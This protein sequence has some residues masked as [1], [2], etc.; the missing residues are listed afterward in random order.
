MSNRLRSIINMCAM[1]G[2]F[3][4]LMEHYINLVETDYSSRNEIKRINYTKTKVKYQDVNPD[5]Y[6]NWRFQNKGNINRCSKICQKGLEVRIHNQEI[7]QLEEKRKIK[8]GNFKIKKVKIPKWKYLNPKF[9][10][11][12]HL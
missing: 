7:K 6:L 9:S 5:N 12:K 10:E 11:P 3:N 1:S 8:Q 4:Y 2:I